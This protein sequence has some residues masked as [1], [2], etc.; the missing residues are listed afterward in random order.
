MAHYLYNVAEIGNLEQV[1]LVVGQGAD[2]NHV[3]GEFKETVT[4]VA[5]ANGHL[6]V[7]RFLVEQGTDMEKS[8][9]NGWTPL[10]TA[11]CGD[12]IEVV[13]YLLEQ[14]ANR[15]KAD[16]TYGQTSLHLAAS[17]GHLEIVKLLMVY[18][19]ELVDSLGAPD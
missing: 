18:V 8:D 19:S 14:G 11:T 6:D 2:K 3:G 16:S 4:S 1:R 17:Y 7:V 13:R 9:K 12:H 5:A 10:L 15:D